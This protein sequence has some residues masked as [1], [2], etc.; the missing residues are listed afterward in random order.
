MSH[1]A[2]LLT[3][4]DF[5]EVVHV[6]ALMMNESACLEHDE[7]DQLGLALANLEVAALIYGT[8]ELHPESAKNTLDL[9]DRVVAVMGEYGLLH[10]KVDK[11]WDEK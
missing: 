8:D 9:I 1:P 6:I 2:A 3:K 11:P 4:E 10:G 5:R 7:Q